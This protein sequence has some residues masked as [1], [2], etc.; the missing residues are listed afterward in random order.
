MNFAQETEKRARGKLQKKKM[1]NV[2][3]VEMRSGWKEKISN[4]KLSSLIR[5]CHM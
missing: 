5:S 3:K 4:V 1:K 2:G